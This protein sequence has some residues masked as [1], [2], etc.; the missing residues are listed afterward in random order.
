MKNI[1]LLC[2]M[3]IH[4]KTVPICDITHTINDSDAPVC[5]VGNALRAKI[6]NKTTYRNG[7]GYDLSHA[8]N[9]NSL[10]NISRKEWL[11]VIQAQRV[12]YARDKLYNIVTGKDY[13]NALVSLLTKHDAL[14]HLRRM[15]G[16]LV[17][18]PVSD[19]KQQLLL[20]A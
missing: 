2:K 14:H 8:N 4:I 3:A 20:S 11:E 12:R 17:D 1:E 7:L 6:I 18:L 16:T 15:E 19:K 9:I 10:L 13:Y 5:L